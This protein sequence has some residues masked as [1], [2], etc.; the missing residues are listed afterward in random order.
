MLA[1]VREKIEDLWGQEEWVGLSGW[2]HVHPWLSA[3]F[4]PEESAHGA[5]HDLCLHPEAT[6]FSG[7]SGNTEQ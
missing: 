3:S 5:N 2:F 6:G 4:R 7:I 1:G